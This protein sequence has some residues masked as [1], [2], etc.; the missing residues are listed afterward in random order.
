MQAQSRVSIATYMLFSLL[1]FGSIYTTYKVG[2]LRPYL[3]IV[4]VGT[5]GL[6]MTSAAAG[7]TFWPPSSGE[8]DI[9]ALFEDPGIP[10]I[11]ETLDE[12]WIGNIPG[13]AFAII[14]LYIQYRWFKGWNENFDLSQRASV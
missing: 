9:D 12:G 13:I 10:Q 14:L 8:V 6:I 11:D 3:L 1:P 4:I 5:A 7:E 2:K